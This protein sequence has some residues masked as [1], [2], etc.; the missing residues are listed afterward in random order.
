MRVIRAYAVMD[1]CAEMR[2]V[3]SR[4][5]GWR[6]PAVANSLRTIAEA[7]NTRGVPT[8]RGGRWQAMTVSNLLARA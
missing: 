2:R 3:P 1:Y 6:R 8:A 5:H 7:L 4:S